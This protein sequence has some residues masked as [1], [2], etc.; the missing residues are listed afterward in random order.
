MDRDRILVDENLDRLRERYYLI[1]LRAL[2]GS[3]P[4]VLPFEGVV[5]RRHEGNQALLVV[6]DGS[7]EELQSQAHHLHCDVEIQRLALEELYRIV[8]R[9]RKHLEN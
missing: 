9:S 5:E 8:V 6:E 2:Q 1:H 7:R 3:L 4:E